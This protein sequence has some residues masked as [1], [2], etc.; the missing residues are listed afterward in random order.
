MTGLSAAAP[1]G[2]SATIERSVVAL[3]SLPATR[4]LGGVSLLAGLYY[5]SARLG[6]ALGFSGPVAAVVWLPAGVAIAF[7]LVGGIG[8]LPGALPGDLLANDYSVLTVAGAV[9]QTLGN[10]GEVVLAAWLVR[11]LLRGTWP[12]DRTRGVGLLVLSLA[13]GTALSAIVGPLS[14]VAS[15]PVTL[16][17]L[18]QV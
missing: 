9:P 18:P 1:G 3:R 14:L 11:R 8:F 5:G 13:A 12:L 17:S 6:F 16:H 7:L 15:G 4:Y 2:S 10:L